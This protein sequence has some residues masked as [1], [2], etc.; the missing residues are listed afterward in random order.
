MDNARCAEAAAKKVQEEL[1]TDGVP[2]TKTL[3][4]GIMIEIPPSL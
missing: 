2:Y 4:I 3:K 1:E